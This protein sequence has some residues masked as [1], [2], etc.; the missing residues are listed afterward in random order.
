MH[1]QDNHG[2]VG[3]I[4]MKQ[5]TP[6]IH[7]IENLDKYP[8]V[9]LLKTIFAE[10]FD[11]DIPI[12]IWRLPETK[13][14]NV[15][16][17][18][19][20]AVKV[21]NEDLESL[22]KGFFI[23]PFLNKNQ[24]KGI[25][26]QADLHFTLAKNEVKF[27]LNTSDIEGKERAEILLLNINKKLK[28]TLFSDNN[29]FINNHKVPDTSSKEEFLTL[30]QNAVKEIENGTFEK[31]VVSRNK[32]IILDEKSE[33]N[34]IDSFLRGCEVYNSA[35]VSLVSIPDHGTWMGATPETLIQVDRN[36]M[37]YT[38]S[39]AGTQALGD[40]SPS[41]ISWTQKEIEEQALVSRYIINCF[42]KIRLRDF[43]EIGPRTVVAGNLLHLRTRFIV[44]MNATGFPELGT[45]M[46]KLLH[47]TSA[48]CGMPLEPAMDFIKTHEN[49]DRDYYSG[50]LGP[51]NVENET[52]L[53]VNLRC[54]QLLKNK[55]IL[56]AGAGI[57]SSS[58]PEK[59]WHETEV[60]CD[61]LMKII[62][63]Q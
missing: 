43:N 63:K 10:A 3:S 7:L 50:Y 33:F 59:E 40:K 54:M 26:L 37:F 31:V 41:E 51:V 4:E 42:K 25:H 32:H 35:F 23:S 21:N 61:T 36:Q 6:V 45:T 34:L 30:V 18:I 28:K 46:L 5:R 48:V 49:Y 1:K 8:L 22:K 57:L 15:I 11:Q 39:L 13:A 19:T 38:D 24:D 16:L 44:D 47:P 17:D 52:H 62:G 27:E 56:Y 58:D 55:A 2:R 9:H 53:Y 29:Y 12:A 14:V 60:K 20:G